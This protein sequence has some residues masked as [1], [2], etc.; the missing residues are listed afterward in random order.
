MRIALHVPGPPLDR[1]VEAIWTVR[2]TSPHRRERVLPA[3]EGESTILAYDPE[4][5]LT[6]QNTQ[7]PVGFPHAEGARG[8]W[9]VMYFE[10]LEGDRTRVRFVMLGWAEGPKADAAY[11]FFERGNAYTLERLKQRASSGAPLPW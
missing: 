2:G 11:A 9:T 8:T 6:I 4:R 10:P 3:L 1:H 5:M 7:A